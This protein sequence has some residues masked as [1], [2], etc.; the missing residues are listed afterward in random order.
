MQ[1]RS[2][3]LTDAKRKSNYFTEIYDFKFD[4]PTFITED[5]F[6][7]VIRLLRVLEDAGLIDFRYSKTRTHK[8]W[9]KKLF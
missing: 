4:L 7:T 2:T 1:I 3:I 5:D 9:I 8:A 6:E